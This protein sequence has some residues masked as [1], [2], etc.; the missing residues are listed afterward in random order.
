MLAACSKDG[1][2]YCDTYV[3]FEKGALRNL[4]N[5]AFIA[6][7][8]TALTLFFTTLGGYGFAKFNFPGKNAL[9]AFLLATMVIPGAVMMVP[10]FII[11]RNIG[12]MDTPWALIVPGA[13]S[14]LWGRYLKS[15]LLALSSQ[16]GAVYATYE[17]STQALTVFLM[18]KHAAPHSIERI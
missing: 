1:K 4:A 17:P 6:T 13:A 9:F 11:I 16:A 7:L 15:S 10:S 8:Y 18:N 2:V 14:A 5:T 12:W 3:I